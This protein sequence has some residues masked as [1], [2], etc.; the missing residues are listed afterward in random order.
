MYA[1][2]TNRHDY[3]VYLADVPPDMPSTFGNG[4]SVLMELDSVDTVKS[5]FKVLKE[6][7]KATMEVQQTFWSECFGS[8]E[9]K[10][11]VSWMLSIEEE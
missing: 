10:F 8:L 7:G 11:G 9:D 1:C 2:L 6:D 5:A 4:T 3:T